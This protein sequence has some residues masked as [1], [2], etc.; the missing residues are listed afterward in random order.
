MFLQ[1]MPKFN[2]DF[3]TTKGLYDR[4]HSSLRG[5][6]EQREEAEGCDQRVYASQSEEVSISEPFMNLYP[7]LPARNCHQRVLSLDT[8]DTFVVIVSTQASE[9]LGNSLRQDQT[10]EQ[11]DDATS[12]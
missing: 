4:L 8:T 7:L 10:L 6:R 2:R 12:Q 11:H 9:T 3:R 1:G 5:A